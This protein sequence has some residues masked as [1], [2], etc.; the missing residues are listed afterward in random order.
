[1]TCHWSHDPEITKL[2]HFFNPVI[3]TFDLWASSFAHT[4]F[5]VITPNNFMMIRWEEY[6]EK[7]EMQ[8]DGHTYRDIR[9]DITIHKAAWSQLK[10]DVGILSYIVFHTRVYQA[11]IHCVKRTSHHKTS[12]NHRQRAALFV[13]S[14]IFR[15]LKR[16]CT[17]A[18]M[19]VYIYIQY[20]TK[21]RYCVLNNFLLYVVW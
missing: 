12:N 7:R 14:N 2:G 9:T 6:S 19:Y 17:C 10:K 1:M 20:D 15:L 11:K 21:Q 8:T 18:Y 4:S 3:L 5:L 13:P 16:S